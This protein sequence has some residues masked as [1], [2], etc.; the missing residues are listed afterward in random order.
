[1]G[2]TDNNE[3]LQISLGNKSDAGKVRAKNEDFM[4]SFKSNSGD[5]FIVCD[6]MGGHIGGEIASKLAVFTI[7]EFIIKSPDDNS[8]VSQLIYG[9]LNAANEALHNKTGENPELNGMGTTCV[10]LILK[11]ETAYFGNVG[12]SRLYLIRNK[13]IYQLSKDQSFVQELVDQG[14]ISSEDAETHP[15]KNEILQALGVNLK[16]EPQLN[17]EGLKVYKNDK[18]LLC[19]DGLSG[20]ISN[21]EILEIVNQSPVMDACD[22]LVSLA[23]FNGGT[24]NITVQ[25]AH[26]LNG[27]VLPNDLKDTPPPGADIKTP[28]KKDEL[29]LNAAGQNVN[30]LHKNN[31]RK[32][33]NNQLYLFIGIIIL[34]LIIIFAAWWIFIRDVNKQDVTRPTEKNIS[35][36]KVIKDDNHSE[37]KLYNFFKDNLYRG[38]NIDGSLSSPSDIDFN[39]IK[40]KTEKDKFAYSI[41]FRQLKEDIRNRDLWL[42]NDFDIISVSGNDIIYSMFI[43]SGKDVPLTYRLVIHKSDNDIFEIKEISFYSPEQTKEKFKRTEKAKSTSTTKNNEEQKKEEINPVEDIKKEGEK[44]KEK[45]EENLPDIKK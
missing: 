34:M 22:K 23:N 2:D 7:K 19:S 39:A 12:D 32:N 42:I 35:E 14:I 36:E 10:I 28:K 38:K 15:R 5:V 24:D 29:K 26:I 4:E 31:E 33:N 1:M 44:V 16:I 40:Y 17:P 30:L 3:R 18:F 20:M 8:N 25:I 6:G 9:A 13:K 27:E 45:I 43:K 37:N 21:K 41:S 11:N